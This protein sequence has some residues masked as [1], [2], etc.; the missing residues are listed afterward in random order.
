MKTH[1]LLPGLER[2]L[3][4]CRVQGLFAEEEPPADACLEPGMLIAGQPCDPL[5]TAVHARV[6]YFR[7]AEG[8]LLLRLVDKHGFDLASVNEEWRRDWSE[9]VREL[10]VF[11]KENVLAYYYATVPGLSSSEGYQPVVRVSVYEEPYAVPLASDVD[12]F[13]DTYSRYLEALVESPF[14]EEDGATALTFPWDVPE[15]IARDQPLVEMLR[16]G[17]F[18]F[19]MEKSADAREWV[20]KVLAASV[21]R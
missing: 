6:G 13:F 1:A 19:L 10:L 4:V 5:L 15:L 9:P 12:R 3:E 8:L 17:C 16:A 11:G 7:L 20:E 2:F 14:Y 18:D 21:R